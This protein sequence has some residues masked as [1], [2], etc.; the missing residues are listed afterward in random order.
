MKILYII[1]GMFNSAG[2]ERVVANKALYLSQ[3]G[4]EITI[5]TTNQ[6]NRAYFYELPKSVKTVDLGINYDDYVGKNIVSKTVAYFHK[7]RLFSRRLQA[8]LNDFRQDVIVT[9]MDRYIPA[10]LRHRKYCVTVYEHHFNK[11]AMYELRE[12]R[13][14][15]FFQQLVYRAKDWYYI[16]FYY[17]RLDVFA[18]LTEE[19]KAYWGHEARNI[20]CM[21]NSILYRPDEVAE[22]DNKIVISIGRL[23]YQKGY[24]RLIQV[25]KTVADKFPDW[26]LHIYGTGEELGALQD[27]IAAL[28]LKSVHIFPPTSEINNKLKE[29]SLYVMTSRFEGL[30]MVLLESMAVGLPLVSFDCKCGPKDV[31]IDGTNGYIIPDGNLEL[32]AERICTLLTNPDKR[33]DMGHQAKLEAKNFSHEKIMKDWISLFNQLKKK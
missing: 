30:P 21:P 7:N 2:R 29:A 24:D 10:I 5:L 25:W 18:V 31:I 9:L 17:R 4:H 16:R 27:Q 15:K 26:Q 32:M 11:F 20:I 1:D 23:T 28:E 3:M 22:L 12:S 33:K 6:R 8:F 19:D 13:T 14:R